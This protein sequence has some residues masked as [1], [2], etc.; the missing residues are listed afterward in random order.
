MVPH[1]QF[2]ITRQFK[3]HAQICSYNVRESAFKKIKKKSPCMATLLIVLNETCFYCC[4]FNCKSRKKN[5]YILTIIVMILWTFT[6]WK[7]IVYRAYSFGETFV[8]RCNLKFGRTNFADVTLNVTFDGI[9]GPHQLR[10]HHH[11]AAKNNPKNKNI[12]AQNIREIK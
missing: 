12:K 1:E 3:H 9:A 6:R 7:Y 2:H 4:L 5:N 11:S 10:V 8:Q